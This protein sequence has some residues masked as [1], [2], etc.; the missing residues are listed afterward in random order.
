MTI[1]KKL[2]FGASFLSRL[3]VN[4]YGWMA[5]KQYRSLKWFAEMVAYYRTTYC[6]HW[7]F[8]AVSLVLLPHKNDARI[9][10]RSK[11]EN[12]FRPKLYCAAITPNYK[13]CLKVMFFNCNSYN[14]NTVCILI[15]IL[16]LIRYKY[17][18]YV[19]IQYVNAAFFIDY[20]DWVFCCFQ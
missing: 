2:S 11:Y 18:M 8:L 9:I 15:C 17:S 3:F 10:A 6:I 12:K 5:S 13:P 16:I 7:A 1:P 14:I 19:L 4:H 20:C